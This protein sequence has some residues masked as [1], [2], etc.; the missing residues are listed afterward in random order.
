M[1][2]VMVFG[3][4]DGLHEGHLDFFRQA[5]EYGDYLV[6]V[7]ARDVNVK[8]IKKRA[9]VK[10]EI[11]RLEILKKCDLVDYSILGYE[12]NPYRIIQEVKPNI[13]CLGYDQKSFNINL[14]GKLKELGLNIKI[15]TLEPYK[16]EKFKSS[17]I[18]KK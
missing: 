16:P 8:K 11:E 3:T 7:V 10:N 14:E 6:A 18:N 2:K 4:F 9:P 15:Y 13:I 1:I 17:I 12:D 5:K